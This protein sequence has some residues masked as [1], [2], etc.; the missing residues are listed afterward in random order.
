MLSPVQIAHP[1]D[2]ILPYK[3]LDPFVRGVSGFL[4]EPRLQLTGSS[5]HTAQ[6]IELEAR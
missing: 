2:H 1:I 3:P 4:A 5:G 6:N